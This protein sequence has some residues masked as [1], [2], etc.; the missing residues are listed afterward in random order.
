M[1][2][3][4]INSYT[5]PCIWI[6]VSCITKLSTVWISKLYPE[7]NKSISTFGLDNTD[8]LLYLYAL[9][10]ELYSHCILSP[11]W[12]NNISIFLSWDAE[13]LK[14]WLDQSCVLVEDIIQVTS[15]LF[16]VSYNSPE[17]SCYLEQS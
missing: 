3:Y 4:G 9:L 17:I 1:A 8:N 10:D 15:V 12:H 2:K 7:I 13:L 14:S 5:C 16:S 11:L 6:H